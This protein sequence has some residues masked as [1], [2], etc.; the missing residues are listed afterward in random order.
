M[1]VVSWSLCIEELGK[2]ARQEVAVLSRDCRPPNKLAVST[3]QASATAERL[4]QWKKR[5]DAKRE[6][7]ARLQEDARMEEEDRLLSLSRALPVGRVQ[8]AALRN[9]EAADKLRWKKLMLESI[10]E[11]QQL[12]EEEAECTFRPRLVARPR[13]LATTAGRLSNPCRPSCGAASAP[14]NLADQP[15]MRSAVLRIRGQPATGKNGDVFERLYKP[16]ADTTAA[17]TVHQHDRTARRISSQAEA[18]FIARQERDQVDRQRRR[19]ERAAQKRYP[20]RPRLSRHTQEICAALREGET[21]ELAAPRRREQKR[22]NATQQT[23]YTIPACT[24]NVYHM[25]SDFASAPFSSLIAALQQQEQR[26]R[27]MTKCA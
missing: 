26:M 7:Q 27:S 14:K 8:A 4:L 16:Q 24:S 23:R 9:Y 6:V 5:N 2:M 1:T 12:D 25:Q 20:H 11:Q 21:D 17:T 15:R 13:R 3:K 10:A 18:A 22:S 19:S